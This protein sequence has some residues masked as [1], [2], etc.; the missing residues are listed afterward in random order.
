MDYR[1]EAIAAAQR[2]GVDPN[3]FLRLV[4]QES[5][6]NSGAVSPKGATG[7]AQLMPGTAAGLGVDPTDPLQ[8][9][10]GGARYLRQQM[11]E[12]G[13]PALALAAYNAGPGAVR[14][15]GGI[16]PY[17]ETQNYVRSIMGAGALPGGSNGSAGGNRM[18]VST[19]GGAMPAGILAMDEEPQTFGQRLKRDFQSGDLMDRIALA[20]NSLRMDPDPNLAA[21]VQG[22]QQKREDKATTNRTAQWLMTQGRADL[23]QALTAGALDPKSAVAMAYQRPDAVSGVEVG[24][25]LIN[26]QTGE[27]IYDAA[28]GAG[29]T[30][31][32]DQ[33]AG[34]NTLRDDLRAE[35][36]MFQIV[37]NGYDNVQAFFSNPSGVSDYA[38][39]VGFAKILDPGSVAREGEVAAVASAG[40]AIPGLAT[41]FENMLNGTGS[42]TPE[43]RNQIAKLAMEIY[44]NK[45]SDAQNTLARYEDIAAQSGLPADLLWTNTPI[46]IP[47]SLPTPP[48]SGSRAMPAPVPTTPTPAPSPNAQTYLPPT[49]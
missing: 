14:K 10:E 27:V 22:R 5:G 32:T 25:R 42:L 26:P 18:S 21:M 11:D 30:L 19:R 44:A 2:N 20:A 31:T 33:M 48:T 37:K 34:L 38:L 28:G 4:G 17:A 43:V 15:Y 47:T 1:A 45:A 36:A 41:K 35:T 6:F 7:L 13:D 8:N 46:S 49:P 12:F 23:A 9:L 24:G 29:A 39:A 40:G 16:P 3:L